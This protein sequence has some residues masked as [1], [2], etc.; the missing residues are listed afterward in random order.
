M[1]QAETLVERV[2]QAAPGVQRLA[3]AAPSP[4]AQLEAGQALLAEVPN[5]YLREVWT[6]IDAH[7]NQLI[8]ETADYFSPGMQVDVIGPVGQPVP[9]ANGQRVLLLALDTSPVPL[10]HLAHVALRKTAE[11]ALVLVGGAQAYPFAGLPPAVEIIQADT[12]ADW[13]D[14]LA[15]LAWPDQVFGVLHPVFGPDQAALL[16][17]LA[18][19]SRGMTLPPEFLYMLPNLPLPCGT[20]ACLACLWRTKTGAKRLCTDGPA[21]DITDMHL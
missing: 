16:F 15:T 7:E 5:A 9:W 8:I 17:H 1:I 13:P 21:L 4:I 19:Q 20:G 3:L 14:Y 2:W 11:V 12:L 10:L 18:Q 6:P